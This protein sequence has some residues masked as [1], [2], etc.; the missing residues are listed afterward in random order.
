[1]DILDNRIVV[2]E[3][4]ET[5]GSIYK[6][7]LE[8]FVNRIFVARNGK[9][10]LEYIKSYKGGLNTKFL[11]KINENEDKKKKKKTRIKTTPLARVFAFYFLS[12]YY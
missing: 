12:W 9:E 1:M 6:E 2:V 3:D 7:W 11:E 8:L 4:D 5:L 10:C